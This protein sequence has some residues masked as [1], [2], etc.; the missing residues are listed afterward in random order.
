MQIFVQPQIL[1]KENCP[2]VSES[3]V[4]NP[5][6][7]TGTGI[8]VNDKLYSLSIHHFNEYLKFEYDVNSGMMKSD[9][10]D[11]NSRIYIK[12]V[13]GNPDGVE[14]TDFGIEIN[15]ILS[16]EIPKTVENKSNEL[17]EDQKKGIEQ[18][19]TDINNI[20]MVYELIKNNDNTNINITTKKHHKSKKKSKVKS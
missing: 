6:I 16:E 4:V 10:I 5:E 9:I 7:V 15:T 12:Y 13:N 8:R 2:E 18:E 14:S 19:F 11:Q 20:N 17:S 1:C 3:D